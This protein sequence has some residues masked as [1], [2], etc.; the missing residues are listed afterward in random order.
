MGTLLSVEGSLL[1]HVFCFCADRLLAGHIK[2]SHKRLYFPED[3]SELENSFQV[4][5]VVP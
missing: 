3:A 4:S 5:S 1:L 2:V